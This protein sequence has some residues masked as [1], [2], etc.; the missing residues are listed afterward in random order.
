M[1]RLTRWTVSLL[2][3]LVLLFSLQS[4]HFAAEGDRVSGT[5]TVDNKTTPLKFVYA[6]KEPDFFDKKKE[7]MVI[8]LSDQAISLDDLEDDFGIIN[9]AK[10]GKVHAIALTINAEKQVTS[11]Q[12][13][14]ELFEKFGSNVSVSGMHEFEP[15]T[16]TTDSIEGKAYVK[17]PQNTFEHQW[18]YEASFKASL[19]KPAPTGTPLPPGGGDPGKTYMAYYKGIMTGDLEALKKLVAPEDAK[20]LDE[21]DAKKMMEMV[22]TMTPTNV[23]ILGGVIDGKSATLEVE[24]V[25][26]GTKT[27]GTVKMR[28]EGTQWR[29]VKEKWKL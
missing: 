5:L 27:T 19:I 11:G 14:H 18:Q 23:K 24:G 26:E 17:G 9:P 15:V 21:P 3:F 28:L 6:R 10:A 8:V 20:Q 16:F 12:L 13:F 2:F 7:Q 1:A 25:M 4:L 22:K 29:L